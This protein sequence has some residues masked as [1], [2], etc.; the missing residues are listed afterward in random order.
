[1]TGILLIT[2]NFHSPASIVEFCKAA[3]ARASKDQ[4]TIAVADNSSCFSRP[5][6][7]GLAAALEGLEAAVCDPGSN[8]GY[9]GG[10]LFAYQALCRQ[11]DHPDWVIVANSDIA[12]LTDDFFSCLQALAVE[13]DVLGVGPDIVRLPAGEPPESARFREN[14]M[15]RSRP[16]AWQMKLRTLVLGSRWL[17]M[18]VYWRAKLRR[19][20]G[21]APS[22]PPPIGGDV[23]MIHGSFMVLHRNYFA[24][25]AGL[26]FPSF[27]FGEEFFVAEEVRRAGGRLR[28][29]PRLRLAHIGGETTGS[30]PSEP[31]RRMELASLEMLTKRYFSG[32]SKI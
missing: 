7:A 4:L 15:R 18:L 6:N 21:S 17:T 24:R 30:I 25:T 9:F 22:G 16:S 10:A 3:R 5:E 11:D 13:A 23:Y 28:F 1:M 31:K 14:P 8:L 2:V 26:N 19:S 32:S 29:E 27:L 12:F 20:S